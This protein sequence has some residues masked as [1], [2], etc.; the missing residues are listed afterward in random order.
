MISLFRRVHAQHLAQE[1]NPE[2]LRVLLLVSPACPVLYKFP[3]RFSL[4]R[5]VHGPRLHVF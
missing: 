2:A 4:F 3:R 5:V 1:L